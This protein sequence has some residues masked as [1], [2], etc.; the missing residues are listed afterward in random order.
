MRGEGLGMGT[1]RCIIRHEGF[2]GRE[3]GG[4]QLGWIINVVLRAAHDRPPALP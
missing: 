3:K 2:I 1:G 4:F